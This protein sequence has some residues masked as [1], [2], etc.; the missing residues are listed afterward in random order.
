MVKL[1]LSARAEEIGRYP[2]IYGATVMVGD[3][4]QLEAGQILAQWDPFYDSYHDRSAGNGQ[5]RRYY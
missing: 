1:P 3:E 5:I 4:Q 2:I